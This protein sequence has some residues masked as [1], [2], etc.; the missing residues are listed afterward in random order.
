MAQVIAH[1]SVKNKQ[2]EISVDLDEAIKVKT[3]KGNAGSALVMPN[4]Y[5]NAKSGDVASQ[6]DLME[7]FGTSDIY[8]V[9]TTIL[10]RGEIEKPQE[11]RD[12]ERELKVKQVINLI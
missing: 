7:A 11:F 3:G 10:T 12:A 4:V 9:A 8:A 2:Y 1:M 5:Y 6:K